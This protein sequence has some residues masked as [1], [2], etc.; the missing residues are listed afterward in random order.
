MQAN[1][2]ALSQIVSCQNVN[3]YWVSRSIRESVSGCVCEGVLRD[4]VRESRLEHVSEC[5]LQDHK[6]EIVSEYIK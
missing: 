5:T 3:D 4:H 2:L 6:R 1:F